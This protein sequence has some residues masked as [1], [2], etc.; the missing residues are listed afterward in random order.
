M[1][2]NIRKHLLIESNNFCHLFILLLTHVCNLYDLTLLCRV[3]NNL[4]FVVYCAWWPTLCNIV[5]Q[6]YRHSFMRVCG[7]HNNALEVCE[8]TCFL[9]GR[10]QELT[11]GVFLLFFL[12][13]SSPPLLLPPFPPFPPLSLASLPLPFHSLS[14]P[15]SSLASLISFPFP[16]LLSVPIP[17]LRSRP[18][19]PARDLGQRC[20]LPQRSPGRSP[21][22]NRIWCTLELLESRW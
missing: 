3:S 9:H 6:N 1:T 16:S 10:R 7:V 22:R 17:S 19:K 4:V 2:L 15:T 5:I 21:G 12:P 11:D 14:L 18:L 8:I 13:P 20:K